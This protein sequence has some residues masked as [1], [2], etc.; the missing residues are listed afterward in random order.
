[1]NN[2]EKIPRALYAIV[3]TR[4]HVDVKNKIIDVD[5]FDSHYLLIAG[6]E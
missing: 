4:E 5:D 6:L 3:D 1:M 2:A